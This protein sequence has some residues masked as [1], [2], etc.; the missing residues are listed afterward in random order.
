MMRET[1]QIGTINHLDSYEKLIMSISV[2]KTE[3]E[4]SSKAVWIFPIPSAP[5]DVQLDT[6][7]GLSIP[8]LGGYYLKD[9]ARESLYKSFFWSYS[10][11]IY[12]IPWSLMN[13]MKETDSDPYHSPFLRLV[14]GG[15]SGESPDIT[16]HQHIEKFGL[17]TELV[18]ANNSEAIRSYLN[19]EG[20]DL[21]ANTGSILEEYI[22]GDFCF[23]VSWISDVDQFVESASQEDYDFYD[24]GVSM[25]FPSENIFF[26]LKLTSVYGDEAIPILINIID[27]V[28]IAPSQPFLSDLNM[29]LDYVHKENYKPSSALTSF[30]EEQ[31]SNSD[32]PIASGLSFE[33]TT[34]IIYSESERFSGDL[35][36]IDSVP[37]NVELS[38]F[39]MHNT[40]PL[41][42]AFVIIFSMTSSLIAGMVVYRTNSPSA[43]RFA[44]LGLLNTLSIIVLIIA[45]KRL[46]IDQRFA[47]V[48][49]EKQPL[50]R[51]R[52]YLFLF[53]LTFLI[54][55]MTVHSIVYF[56]VW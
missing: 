44:L 19:Q 3:L 29:T 10:S 5:A 56:T 21:P 22:G 16:V 12:P 47:C 49:L 18:T 14:F 37:T 38:R 30:F 27:P 34:I 51:R 11:Q 39:V 15:E 41:A 23:A 6:V 4:N 32:N 26:P 24:L 17:A 36:L 40:I 1:A 2:N 55:N 43:L 52:D 42:F 53:T 45:S 54:T 8:N 33:Y 46:K 48:D 25:G 20:L 13:I 31:N 28:V 35:W 50:S 9:Y 7:Q